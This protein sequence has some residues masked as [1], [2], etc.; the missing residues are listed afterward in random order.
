LASEAKGRWFDSSQPH[1]FGI[2]PSRFPAPGVAVQRL[3][4]QSYFFLSLPYQSRFCCVLLTTSW[5]Q[6]SAVHQLF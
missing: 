6:V 4:R 2:M 3:P 1:Q 5:L